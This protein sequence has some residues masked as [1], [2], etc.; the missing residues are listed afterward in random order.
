M[1]FPILYIAWMVLDDFFPQPIAVDVG[2]NFCCRNALM[3]Q[4]TLYGTQ[5]G[6]TLQQMGSKGVPERVGADAFGDARFVRQLLYQMKHHNARN[7][8]S[9]SR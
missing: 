2:V 5:I 3:S 4:H 7:V 8:L 6:T 1:L 9:P